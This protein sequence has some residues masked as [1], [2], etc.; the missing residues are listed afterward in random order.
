MAET[1]RCD[2]GSTTVPAVDFDHIRRRGKPH[3]G[4]RPLLYTPRHRPQHG[5]GKFHQQTVNVTSAPAQSDASAVRLVLVR[6]S[7]LRA[8]LFS[9]MPRKPPRRRK[10]PSSGAAN[11]RSATQGQANG[12]AG[13]RV[14]GLALPH[15]QELEL[16]AS[17]DRQGRVDRRRGQ[18]TLHRHQ[19]APCQRQRALPLRGRLG[20][21]IFPG[22]PADA[23]CQGMANFGLS[24]SL[25]AKRISND[26]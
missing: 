17:G 16:R 21:Q 26:G 2:N 4:L 10:R 22:N 7:I 6:L 13:T 14:R 25:L 12:P 23:V 18:S 5:H 24:S 15:A 3:Q 1:T 9:P 11:S 20:L 19:C 8:T